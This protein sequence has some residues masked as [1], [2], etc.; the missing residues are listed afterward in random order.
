MMHRPI[1]WFG[2]VLA[3]LGT[4]SGLPSSSPL[5][6][7]QGS[8]PRLVQYVQSQYRE[9]NESARLSITPLLDTG[10]T[11]VILA[12]M[13]QNSS[14]G[15][16][17]L[18]DNEIN[19]TY[20][21]RTWSEAATLQQNGIKIMVM[22]GGSAPGSYNGTTCNADGSINDDWYLPIMYTLKYHNVDGLD[23]DIEEQVPI[24][25]PENLVKR[26]C[27]DFGD[28][29]IITMAPVATDLTPTNYGLS[30]FSYK[31]FDQSSA[32]PLVSWYNTQYYSGFVIGSIEDSYEAAVNNGFSASRVVMGVLDSSVDGSGWENLTNYDEIITNLKSNYSDFGG[33]D[34]WEYYNAGSSDGITHPWVWVKDIA[35]TLFGT[36]SKRDISRS[37][38]HKHNSPLPPGV[39]QLMSEGYDQ[40]HAAAAMRW[41]QEDVD[42]ARK[43]LSQP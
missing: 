10:V 23:L 31:T 2:A 9:N 7:R 33:V 20:Y 37:T 17:T 19:S 5:S 24:A 6:K 22:L 16:L 26:L 18:N 36:S 13:H 39:A 1:V 14:P 30:G 27:S 40:I 4:V 15:N 32:G 43:I 21:K 41:A 11:H 8:V 29:F 12:A 42:E 35:N 3:L 28:N 25:C 34:A 38:R